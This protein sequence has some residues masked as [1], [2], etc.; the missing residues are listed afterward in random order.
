MILKHNSC[1]VEVHCCGHGELDGHTVK[2]THGDVKQKVQRSE[3]ADQTRV[4]ETI[5]GEAGC[6][7]P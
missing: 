6:H 7:Y 4:R 5:Q 2:Y 3:E 1:R